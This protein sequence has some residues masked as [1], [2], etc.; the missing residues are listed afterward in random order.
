MKKPRSGKLHG[1]SLTARGS[2]PQSIHNG[3]NYLNEE[4][5]IK[6]PFKHA[7]CPELEWY[8]D[9]DQTSDTY[10]AQIW[11]PIMRNDKSTERNWIMG[12]TCT[13]DDFLVTVEKDNQEL[14]RELHEELTKLGCRAEIRQ[15]KSGFV[16]SY[17]KNKK[18]ILNYVFRKKG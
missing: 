14:V 11:I 3:W 5:L 1:P 9:G 16:V 6:Y 4:W 17:L 7:P 13:Y 8:S 2:I 10:K 15:A 18:T 12:E